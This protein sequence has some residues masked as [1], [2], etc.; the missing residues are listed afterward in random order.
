MH[1]HIA[2]LLILVL[3]WGASRV[4]S[5]VTVCTWLSVLVHGLLLVA[6]LLLIMAA[7]KPADY[8]L[9]TK[10]GLQQSVQITEFRAAYKY[11]GFLLLHAT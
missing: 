9:V 4:H 7:A 1:K 3:C 8:Y 2:L 10:L 11:Y 6:V 5:S